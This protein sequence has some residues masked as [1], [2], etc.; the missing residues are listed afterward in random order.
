MKIIR[1]FIA[2]LILM[3]SLITVSYAQNTYKNEVQKWRE[4][5]ETELKSENSWLSLAG[6]FWLKEGDNTIGSDLANDIKLPKST[7]QKVGAI[8]FKDGVA[9]LS[10][11]TDVKAISDGKP[12]TN[13]ELTSDEKGKP[14]LIELGDVS[15]TLIRRENRFGIR[16][17]DKNNINRQQFKGLNW[18]P[19]DESYRVEADF[20][21]YKEP[22]VIDIPN[23]LGGVYKMKSFGL[24][25]FKIKGKPY[26]LEPVEE[27]DKFF[28]IF[29][30][31]TVRKTTYQAGRFLDAD[32]PTGGKVIL[33]FNEAYN[34][35]CAFTE[36][37]TCPLPPP[38]NRLKVEIK[39]GEKRY[40]QN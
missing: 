35:P 38:Q 10:V 36:F 2:S 28:I 30:D 1:N 6:L 24:L 13:L 8:E 27:G 18:F 12:I 14:T 16:V 22:K 32:K 7:A 40:E 26:T 9:K 17:K 31:L 3:T 23:V 5:T 15:F 20:E 29:N 39:A 37:A 19:I 34:P 33:D 21:A 25:K 4:K 11:N